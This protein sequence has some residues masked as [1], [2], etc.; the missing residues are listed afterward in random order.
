MTFIEF[1]RTHGLEIDRLRSGDRI[2]RCPTTAHPRSKNGAYAFDGKRG[3]V[4]NWE[5]GEALQWW[6]D[7]T[8]RPW[9][10]AEKREWERKRQRDAA[11]RAA[12]AKKAADEAREL[13]GS[14]TMAP[15]N[16]LTA[17]GLDARG[18]V[19]PDYVLVVPMRGIDDGQLRGAQT[20]ALV[21][22]QWRKKFIFG[23]RAK[24]AVLRIGPARATEAYLV[25]GY[26]TGLSVEAAARRLCLSAAI[27]VTFSADNLAHVAPLIRGRRYVVADNDASG[28]GQR[29]AEATGLPWV[30]S[31]RVGEDANDLHQRA[32]V[33][34]LANLMMQCRRARD[35]GR[36]A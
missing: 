21:D 2:F 23:T 13:I 19:T 12:L 18:L 24:G 20:I 4:Q 33:M 15:H 14:A 10:D 22:N 8:A 1:A 35:G 29:V 25:E 26:A 3:W 30:M 9:T 36:A 32:G 17:K 28:T 27:Y 16:Y 11:E 7:P 34:A 5:T 6:N 31:D